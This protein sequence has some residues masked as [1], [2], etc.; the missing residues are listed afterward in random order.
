MKKIMYIVSTL[1]RTGPTNQLFN[2]IKYLDRSLFVPCVVTLSPEPSDSRYEDFK[3]LGVELISLKLS[4]LKGLFVAK[5]KIK[6][7][8][9]D[10][11]PD[12]VHTQGVRADKI[13]SSL[14]TNCSWVMTARNDPF[15]DYPMKFG[16]LKGRLMAWTHIRAMKKC[17][18]IIACSSSISDRLTSY[19]VASYV[20]HNGVEFNTAGNYTQFEDESLPKPIF[21]TVGS[22]IKRKNTGTL[23]KAFKNYLKTKTGSLIVLG[24][25]PEMGQL[26]LSAPDNV[27]FYG[28]VENVKCF[29]DKSSY[30]VSASLSEGLPNTVLEALHSGVPAILSD[31]PP[32]AEIAVEA[33]GAC[34][35]FELDKGCEDL[36]EKML[37]ISNLFADDAASCA[38]EGARKFF[39]AEMMSQKYQRMYSNIAG[40][41]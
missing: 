18:Q 40:V 5:A 12:I 6:Q 21:I 28:N 17:P 16:R 2:I 37:N 10:F 34:V 29:L 38:T 8:I 22:L 15:D 11:A 1:K 33:Q 23:L 3:T 25:G 20:I 7:I 13:L 19:G 41:L 35:L 39:S 14:K 24:D 30:F 26:K 9:E 36:T 27:F 32:H 31:I 4:R